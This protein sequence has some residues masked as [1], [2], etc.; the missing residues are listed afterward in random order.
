MI[1][2][3]FAAEHGIERLRKPVWVAPEDHIKIDIIDGK[4]GPWLHLWCPV[5]TELNG[6]DP[7]DVYAYQWDLTIR[8]FVP[9]H[10]PLPASDEY[11]AKVASFAGALSKAQP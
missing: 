1:S 2:L 6:R 4:I 7:V 5:N 8:E 3:Q 11:R 10:G 9:Y